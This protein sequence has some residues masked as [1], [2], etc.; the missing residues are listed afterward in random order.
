VRRQETDGLA[1][2]NLKEEGTMLY[3]MIARRRAPTIWDDMFNVRNRFDRVPGWRDAEAT[4]AWCPAVD[5][6]ETKDELTLH[7]ELPGISEEAVD[8][9]VE[10]GVLT[11][12]GERKQQTEEETEG[13]GYHLV[14]RCYG[15][16]ERRFSLPRSVDSEKVRAAFA[17]G[18]LTVTL[19]KAETAKPRKIE[20]K[21]E[22]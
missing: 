13:S 16:F 19:P 22:K 4:T 6:R 5:I 10:N 15:H 17:H 1:S 14:E 12:S 11:I 20:V 21:V 8:V 2:V 9:S 3:P 18:V 7:V